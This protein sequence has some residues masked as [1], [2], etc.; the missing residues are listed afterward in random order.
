MAT[1]SKTVEN[2]SAHSGVSRERIQAALDDLMNNKYLNM[3]E[4]KYHGKKPKI[5]EAD[6]NKLKADGL[7]KEKA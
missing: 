4:K 6:W 7:W 2:V 5:L 3:T 1:Y